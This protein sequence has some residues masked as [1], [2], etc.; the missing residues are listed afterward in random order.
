MLAVGQ[1]L[2]VVR[3]FHCFKSIKYVYCMLAVFCRSLFSL[4]FCTIA[5][6]CTNRKREQRACFF[7]GVF[8]FH[9]FFFLRLNVSSRVRCVR[10]SFN[11]DFR[12]CRHQLC[13]FS[14][15]CFRPNPH[16]N[17]FGF[18]MTLPLLTYIFRAEAF[19]SNVYNHKI[20]IMLF[21]KASGHAFRLT[22]IT[23]LSK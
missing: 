16:T 12:H 21:A 19:V 23:F 14:F 18:A 3:S 22:S 5:I 20:M 10:S 4:L 13:A 17:S 1:C 7:S 9:C 8:C 2:Y 11:S 6:V 15:F